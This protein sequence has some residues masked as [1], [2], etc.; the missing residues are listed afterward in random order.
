V[1]CVGLQGLCASCGRRVPGAHSTHAVLLA[2]L[3]LVGVY[4]LSARLSVMIDGATKP[5][6]F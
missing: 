3:C 5:C 4:F 2:V 6:E 1:T